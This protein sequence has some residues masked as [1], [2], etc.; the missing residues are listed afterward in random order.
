[1][2]R[3][4]KNIGK[5]I[6]TGVAIGLM[7][8]SLAGSP[9]ANAQPLWYSTPPTISLQRIATFPPFIPIQNL[10]T[11]PSFRSI[12]DMAIFPPYIPIQRITNPTYY[13]PRIIY[14]TY[15]YTN[16]DSSYLAFPQSPAWRYIVS[17]RGLPLPGYA[18]WPSP[19]QPLPWE[20]PQI[21]ERPQPQEQLPN[22]QAQLEQPKEKSL[23]EKV[24]PPLSEEESDRVLK[25]TLNRLN[26]SYAL[27]V[28]KDYK[29]EEI[30]TD[31][32]V[33]LPNEMVGIFYLQDLPKIGQIIGMCK[34]ENMRCGIF[35][36]HGEED[37]KKSIEDLF[38]KEN[39]P[40]G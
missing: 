13:Y 38:Q 11:F 8:I 14:S 5:K 36:G 33:L 31:A 3:G 29:G 9:N 21:F 6:A 4:L 24:E 2:I 35:Y 25:E 18:R 34:E 28:V 17:R 30:E 26:L 12:R 27:N 19:Y 16:L 37:F 23:E 32:I 40:K 15:P 39:K 22:Y 10:A 20:K 7:S 1:M